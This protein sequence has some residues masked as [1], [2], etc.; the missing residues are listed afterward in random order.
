MEAVFI[1]LTKLINHK[2]WKKLIVGL[3]LESLVG[4]TFREAIELYLKLSEQFSLS[5][6]EISFE[7]DIRK[8]S[9]WPWEIGRDITDFLE[10]FEIVGAHL[11]FVYLNPICP[12]PKIRNESINQLKKA[13]EKASELNMD[14]CVM[15][16]RGFSFG[17]TYNKQLE[18]W[19][20]IIEDLTN[21]AEENSILLT[22]ENADSLHD[23]SDLVRIVREINSKSLKITLDLGHAHIRKV[24]PLSVFPIKDLILRA[25]DAIFPVFL[26]IRKNMPYEAY[27]SLKNFIRFEN[28]LIGCVHVHDYNGKKDHLILGEGKIDFSFLKDL[29]KYFK[30]PYIFEIELKNYYD[31]FKR[32]Y[33]KFKE[34]MEI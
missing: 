17:L 18:E 15:H 19:R 6:V 5:A 4:L 7:K 1:M 27:G 2:K 21:Y 28:D 3:S 24:A 8:P 31:D 33:E 29:K 14:Y 26:P 10:N 11:P 22:V 30:G 13:I 34:V 12:N 9:L 23:L 20:K 16:A 25:M 32:S